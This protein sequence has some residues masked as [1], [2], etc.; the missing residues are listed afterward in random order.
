MGR[1]KKSELEALRLYEEMLPLIEECHELCE[2][3]AKYEAE[4]KE[5]EEKRK[6]ELKALQERK[7]NGH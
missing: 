3:F 4:E 5:K 7:K 1:K 6:A 2:S